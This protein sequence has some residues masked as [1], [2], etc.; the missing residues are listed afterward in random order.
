MKLFQVVIA[1]KNLGVAR[2]DSKNFRIVRAFQLL[3]G[4]GG[5]LDKFAS[6]WFDSTT[7]AANHPLGRTTADSEQFGVSF[8]LPTRPVS[9]STR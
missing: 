9:T 6:R 7:G 4:E 8:P 3:W 1:L 2:D 5:T